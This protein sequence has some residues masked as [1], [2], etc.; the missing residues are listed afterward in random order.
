MEQKRTTPIVDVVYTIKQTTVARI[1]AIPIPADFFRTEGNY[2][3]DTHT[4]VVSIPGAPQITIKA[5]V[6]R[7]PATMLN[8]YSKDII[9]LVADIHTI[10]TKKSKRK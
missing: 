3:E 10:Y 8:N 7:D 2:K 5:K 6:L 9:A 1:V 4:Y